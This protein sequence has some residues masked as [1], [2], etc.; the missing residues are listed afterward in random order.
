MIILEIPIK[1]VSEANSSE[2]WSVKSKRHRQQQ[3]FVRHAYN[4]KI[5]PECCPLPC[6]IKMIRIGPRIIDDDNLVSS[7]KWVRDELAYLI[8][9]EISH[10]KKKV[11][12]AYDSDERIKWSYAQEKSRKYC[13]RIEISY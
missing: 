6:S 8:L 11:K 1:A 3:F 13:I 9:S 2:H 7:L 5:A 12:G 10:T 4:Q